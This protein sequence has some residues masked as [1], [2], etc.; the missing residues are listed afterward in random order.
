MGALDLL[1]LLVGLRTENAPKSQT[2]GQSLLLGQNHSSQLLLEMERGNLET[3]ILLDHPRPAQQSRFL[4]ALQT[5][6]CSVVMSD[7]ETE[8]TAIA[9]V[10]LPRS[11]PWEENDILLHRNSQFTMKC[12]PTSSAIHPICRK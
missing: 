9:N 3:L 10:V 6:S 7:V 5:L 11:T 4:A 1:P 12:L 2:G 8:Y